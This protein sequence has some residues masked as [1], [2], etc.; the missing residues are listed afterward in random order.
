MI[1]LVDTSVLILRERNAQVAEW[2]RAQLLADALA[3]CEMV[4]MEYLFGARNGQHYDELRE[5]LGA[6]RQVS[7]EPADWLRASEVQRTLAH[8]TGGGQR[9]VKIPDLVIAATAERAQLPLIHYDEDYERIAAITGQPAS[10][11]APRGTV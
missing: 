7:I 2:F 10:W 1:Q 4:S 9:A 8:Q 11:V 6:L 3:V 5:A